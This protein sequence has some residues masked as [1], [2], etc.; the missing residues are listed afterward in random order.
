MINP[1]TGKRELAYVVSVTDVE[2]IEG[3]DRV[4]K[5]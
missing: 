4:E 3:Y 1:K 5:A 2:P